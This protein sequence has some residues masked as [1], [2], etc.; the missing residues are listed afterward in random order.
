MRRTF[1]LLLAL[2]GCAGPD[3]DPV[4]VAERF[5]AV[6][7]AG[8]DRGI[9]ALLTDADRA[10]FPLEAFPADLPSGAV[11]DILG[12]GDAA[13]ESAS[14]LET[15][16]DTAAVVLQV[17][18]GARDT[19]RLVA[20]HH[21][22]RLWRFEK[23]RVRWRVSM[24]LAERALV[25]SLAARMRADDRATDSTAMHQVEA[26]L[27]AADRYPDLARPADVAAARSLLRTAAV[28]RALRIE[29]RLGE[30][31]RGV[32]FLE[33]T[34]E[35]PTGRRVSTLRLIVRDAAGAEETLELWNV[36]A[37]GA[38]PVWQLTGLRKGPVSHRVERIQVF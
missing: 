33:G 23:D 34:I 32:P 17:E 2:G 4:D 10:A 11:L 27:A 21:P 13:L 20:A 8:D 5:H 6:R 15:S 1:L 26:Y 14:L 3:S 16:G 38:T 28:A 37:E 22:L 35:N 18:G 25:D 7:L 12:W 31:L 19:L 9:H 29:L 24:G 30:S 36:A